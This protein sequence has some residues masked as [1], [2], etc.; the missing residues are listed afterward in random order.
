MDTICMNVRVGPRSH[1]NRP[2]GPLSPLLD[3][4]LPF[5]PKDGYDTLFSAAGTRYGG[6]PQH[7]SASCFV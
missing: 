6:R 7:N 5:P 4:R 1:E 3:P 2:C